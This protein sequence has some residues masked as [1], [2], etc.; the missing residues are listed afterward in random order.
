MDIIINREH[1]S[2]FILKNL[3]APCPQCGIPACG[4]E[5]FF[6][7]N[8][9]EKRMTLVLDGSYLDLII[10]NYLNNSLEKTTYT[11]LPKFLRESN[12]CIGWSEADDFRGTEIDIDDLLASI[13]LIN[14][15][16]PENW[17]KEITAEY[18]SELSAICNHAKRFNSK[19]FLARS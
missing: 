18:T 15:F 10:Q 17:L 11:P 3:T 16:V 6:W 4:R 9:A 7:Y 13:E 5:D 19:L 2:F 12:E 8:E 14:Q 1:F